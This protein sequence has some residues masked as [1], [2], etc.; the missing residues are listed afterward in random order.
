[1]IK[2][3]SKWHLSWAPH[4]D[5]YIALKIEILSESVYSIFRT[6]SYSNR[7]SQGRKSREND[8]FGYR[9]VNSERNF[10]SELWMNESEF[11]LVVVFGMRQCMEWNK[12]L[13]RISILAAWSAM[14]CVMINSWDYPRV[15]FVL[16]IHFYEFNLTLFYRTQWIS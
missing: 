3:Y 1:M 16:K 15:I 4:G 5:S 13:K 10:P 6:I 12:S 8:I 2:F 7:K 11:S 14:T 9:N